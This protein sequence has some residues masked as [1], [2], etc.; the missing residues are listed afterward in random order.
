MSRAFKDILGLI[1]YSLHKTYLYLFTLFY[2]VKFESLDLTKNMSLKE[3][4]FH[5]LLGRQKWSDCIVL[6]GIR[7][8]GYPVWLVTN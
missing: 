7:G 8:V 2:C 4:L 5:N 3:I 6:E 1:P